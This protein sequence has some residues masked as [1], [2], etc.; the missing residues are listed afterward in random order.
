MGNMY[1]YNAII[2]VQSKR[3]RSALFL[4]AVELNSKLAN[5]LVLLIIYLSYFSLGYTQCDDG[6][7]MID[8]ICYYQTDIDIL[9]GIIENSIQ[10]INMEMDDDESGTIEPLEL[11][12]QEW[13]EGRIIQLNCNYFDEEWI[14][15]NIS[16]EILPSIGNLESLT[17]LDLAH[18]QLIGE[19]P[20]H[21]GNLSNL[22]ILNLENNYLTSISNNL[23]QLYSLEYLIFD[24][25]EFMYLPD[26]IGLLENLVSLSVNNNQLLFLPESIGE[27]SSLEYL[28]IRGN[29]LTSVP[30]SICNLNVIWGGMDCSFDWSFD[31]SNNQICPPYPEC[32][33]EYMGYQNLADCSGCL[34]VIGD[35]NLDGNTGILDIMSVINCILQEECEN[36][37]DLNGDGNVNI[38]DILQ[39]VNIILN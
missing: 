30:E 20:S 11:G 24:N 1:N 26:Q 7:T 37:T 25:N 29:Y 31:I 16:G 32:I 39:L 18:N 22:K 4:R 35:I 3:I 10:T 19:I 14:F 34:D 12:E 27:L 13:E 2:L 36:C 8:S 23:V 21:L 33:E 15:C 28:T 17:R 9:Q 5:K 6:F 38:L